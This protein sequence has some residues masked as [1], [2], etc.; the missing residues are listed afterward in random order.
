MDVSFFDHRRVRQALT[1]VLLAGSLAC[2]FPPKMPIF[3]WWAERAAFVALGFLLAGIFFLIV[4]KSRLMFV[5]LGCSAA[6]CFFKNE[7]NEKMHPTNFKPP[8]S[9]PVDT[10]FQNRIFR[11]SKSLKSTLPDESPKTRR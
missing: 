6:I 11:D 2:I 4:N 3:Q 8:L 1:V 7:M 9:Q 10:P 5:C